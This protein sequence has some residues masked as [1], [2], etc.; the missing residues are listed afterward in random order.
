MPA[1][2]VTKAA[3]KLKKSVVCVFPK[4]FCGVALQCMGSQTN[5]SAPFITL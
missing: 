3:I 1:L 4:T 5:A 2:T